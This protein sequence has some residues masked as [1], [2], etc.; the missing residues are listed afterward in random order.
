MRTSRLAAA[1]VLLMA[2]ALLGASLAWAISRHGTATRATPRGAAW[3]MGYAPGG[4]SHPVS[5]LTEARARA[6]TFARRLGDVRVDEVLQFERNYYARL[7]DHHGAGAAEVLVDPRTGVVSLEYGPAMM[8]NTRYGMAGGRLAGM[9]NSAMMG[10][11]GTAMMGRAG[12]GMMTGSGDMMDGA[13]TTARASTPVSMSDAHT[14][15]QRW[16]DA[17]DAGVQVET[18]GDRFPGYFTFETLRDGRI[19]GMISVRESTGAVWRHWWHG[20]FVEKA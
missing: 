3:M 8:W 2:V 10:R 7:V 17:Q 5:N 6:A 18:G 13:V 20:A 12:G 1:T 11:Y 9:P 15:A 4:A 14:L 19:E 16:L